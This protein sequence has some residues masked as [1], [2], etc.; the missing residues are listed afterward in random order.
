MAVTIVSNPNT[1]GGTA[2]TV[3]EITAPTG[4][5]VELRRLL[6][7]DIV[8]FWTRVTLTK[9]VSNS[10]PGPYIAVNGVENNTV[11]YTSGT[12]K[13]AGYLATSGAIGNSGYP[14]QI[15]R[16]NVTYGEL[17]VGTGTFKT[18]DNTY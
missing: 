5:R 10:Y 12:P 3:Q 8:Y 17:S 1:L 4:W 6:V 14:T 11:G 13:K 7:G 18:L 16:F 15:N 9:D 2:T